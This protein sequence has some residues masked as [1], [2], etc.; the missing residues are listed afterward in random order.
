MGFFPP[1]S[2]C[3]KIGLSDTSFQDSI[4][5]TIAASQAIIKP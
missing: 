1:T 4:E 3:P 5:N 2:L